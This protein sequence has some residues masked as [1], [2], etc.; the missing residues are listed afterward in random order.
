MDGVSASLV[1]AISTSLSAS[2]VLSV[3]SSTIIDLRVDVL[4]HHEYS[5]VGRSDLVNVLLLRA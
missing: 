5:V 1:D 2:Q 4:H 3:L